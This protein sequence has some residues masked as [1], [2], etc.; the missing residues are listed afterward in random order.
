MLRF[1]PDRFSH[2]N[3]KK[4]SHYDFSPFGFAGKRVCPGQK[5]SYTEG[6]VALVTLLR[7]FKV[8]MVDGQVIEPVH[9]LV[10]HPSDEVW[11]TITKR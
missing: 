3:S 7:K 8:T 6:T 11:I 9:G 5:F 4:R 2:E 10:T 1:D